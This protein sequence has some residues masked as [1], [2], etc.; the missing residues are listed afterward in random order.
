MELL[1]EDQAQIALKEGWFLI[2]GFMYSSTGTGYSFYKS[3]KGSTAID[4]HS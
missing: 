3:L 2:G 1:F 4:L